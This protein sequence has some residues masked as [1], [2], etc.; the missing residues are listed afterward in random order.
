VST[1]EITVRGHGVATSEPDEAELDLEISVSRPTAPDA[2]AEAAERSRALAAALDE[3]GVAREE[4]GTSGVSVGENHEYDEKG[5]RQHRGYVARTSLSV[6]L[7]SAEEVGPV[8]QAAVERALARVHGPHWRLADDNPAR[9]EACRLASAEARRKAEAYAEPLGLRLGVVT[10]AAEP[11]VQLAARYD[12]QFA[13][14]E[15]SSGPVEVETPRLHVSAS[16]DV[17][18]ALEPA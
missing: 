6:R 10:R 18:F 7:R 12:A 11:Q 13:A 8:L 17:S 9:L 16:I 15:A 14:L 5:R 3:L 1:A 2:L 4:R